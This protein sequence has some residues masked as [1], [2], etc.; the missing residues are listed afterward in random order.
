MSRA[1]AAEGS[2]KRRILN[3]NSVKIFLSASNGAA[4]IRSRCQWALPEIQEAESAL[5]AGAAE[6]EKQLVGKFRVTGFK[7]TSHPPVKK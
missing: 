2:C 1:R 3:I 6:I 7:R 5:N 4:A